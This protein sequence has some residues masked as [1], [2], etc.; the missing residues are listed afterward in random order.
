MIV[1]ET[2]QSESTP[3][4]SYCD[5]LVVGAGPVGMLQALLFQKAGFQVAVV[6]RRTDIDQHSRAIGIHPPGLASLDQ[7]GLATSFTEKGITVTGGWAYVDGKPVGRMGFDQ[8][9]GLWKYPVVMPQHSTERILEQALASNNIPVYRGCSFVGFD[10]TGD[11]VQVAVRDQDYVNHMVSCRLLVG[12]DGKRSAV[13]S[14]IGTDW[15]GGKYPDRY[16]MG[17]FRDQGLFEADAVIN[18]HREGMVESFPLPDGKRRW[19]AR[20]RHDTGEP[21]VE[22]LV[23]T[24]R[25]R[26]SPEVELDDCTMFSAFGIERWRADRLVKGRVVLAGDAAHVV[27]PIGGQGMNLGWMDASD[28]KRHLTVA[29]S[30][31]NSTVLSNALSTYELGVQK[32]AKEGIRRA[33]FNTVLG[34]SGKFKY[35]KLAAAHLIVNTGMQRVFARRFTMGDL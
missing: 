15:N 8:N 28:L 13:R 34:R 32:R 3:L 1:D 19:V 23:E 31:T 20:L 27:S 11:S 29:G 16:I 35:L 9:P 6:D 26:M 2:K 10:Q 22:M 4:P 7:V 24:V 33:W 25:A 30:L 12:C 21:N 17:D 18:L 14:A 5:I